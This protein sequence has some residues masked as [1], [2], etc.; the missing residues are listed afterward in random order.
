MV[1]DLIHGKIFN[2]QKWKMQQYS[3]SAADIDLQHRRVP[4]RIAIERYRATYIGHTLRKESEWLP[5]QVL[6][7]VMLPG[8]SRDCEIGTSAYLS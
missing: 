5:R 6:L 4:L 7:G 8:I 1:E 2:I 3:I